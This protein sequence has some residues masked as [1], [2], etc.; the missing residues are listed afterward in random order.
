MYKINTL[1]TKFR[2]TTETGL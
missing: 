1:S 2:I